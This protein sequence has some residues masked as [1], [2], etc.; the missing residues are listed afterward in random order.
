MP[1]MRTITIRWVIGLALVLGLPAALTG[2]AG[3]TGATGADEPAQAV[4]DLLRIDGHRELYPPTQAAW[5]PAGGFVAMVTDGETRRLT[6]YRGGPDGR[7][8]QRWIELPA[9]AGAVEPQLSIAGDRVIVA[10]AAGTRIWTIAVPLSPQADRK[11]LRASDLARDTLDAGA[12]V[13][14]LA[15]DASMPDTTGE[16]F[17]HLAYLAEPESM[18]VALNRMALASQPEKL[19]LTVPNAPRETPADGADATIADSTSVTLADS[20]GAAS[21]TARFIAY[22]RSSDAGLTWAPP[23]TLAVGDLDRPGLFA[24]IAG[25]R[26]V[27]LCYRRGEFMAWR[28]SGNRGDAWIREKAIRMRG[29]AG[30]R[31]AVARNLDEVFLICESDTHQVTGSTSL[32]QGYNWE[33]AIAVAR[34]SRSVRLPALDCGG[35]LFWVAYSAGDSVV[36]LRSTGSTLYPKQWNRGINIAAVCTAGPPDVVALPDS[37]AGLIYATPA[38]E[39]YF[40]R[41]RQPAK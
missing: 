39:V 31:N 36:V 3:A 29:A 1:G 8:W 17:A 15:L 20:A 12:P 30:S 14:S 11:G 27:D 35:G 25:R 10:G 28:G 33:R 4:L 40:A 7:R 34:E 24:H 37:T 16:V 21:E 2:A 23:E 6:L 18:T 19:R 9:A 26:S 38:G 5:S 13:L 22:L 41:V 32:N